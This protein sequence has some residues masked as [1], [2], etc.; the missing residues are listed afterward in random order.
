MKDLKISEITEIISKFRDE[1]DWKQFHNL[2]DLALSLNLEAS[3]VLEHFQWKNSTEINIFDADKKDKIMEE[4]ADVLY[5]IVL[6]ANDL[7]L[8]LSEAFINKMKKNS[9]KYP[10]DKSKGQN[11]KYTE[12]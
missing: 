9:D 11:T 8:N 2:K 7:E 5:W 3:E 4:L 12:L 10:V 6:M 1:R